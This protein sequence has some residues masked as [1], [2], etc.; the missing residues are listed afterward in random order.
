MLS[1]E[2]Q[3]TGENGAYRI[4]AGSRDPSGRGA[5]QVRASLSQERSL[6]HTLSL[7]KGTI[8]CCWRE[9]RAPVPPSVQVK[10]WDVNGVEPIHHGTDAQPTP[11]KI[12]LRFSLLGHAGPVQ[13][14]AISS[15]LQIGASAADDLAIIVWDLVRGK[16]R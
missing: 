10:V 14:V 6:Y 8:C 9:F 15:N 4:I 7:Q 13:S 2:Q 1:P 12:Q 3:D 16:E 11:P 5:C